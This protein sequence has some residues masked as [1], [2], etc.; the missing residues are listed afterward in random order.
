MLH[1]CYLLFILCLCM[2]VK[3]STELMLYVV[4]TMPTLIYLLFI[5]LKIGQ[6]EITNW[7]LFRMKSQLISKVS[8]AKSLTFTGIQAR[9]YFINVS[10]KGL[11][12]WEK[13][14]YWSDVQGIALLFTILLGFFL[15]LLIHPTLF[16]QLQTNNKNRIVVYSKHLNFVLGI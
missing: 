5:Y 12:F 16:F 10:W 11:N 14:E 6:R 7:E 2:S 8:S 1:A 3:S 15:L 13:Q 9:H 4:L